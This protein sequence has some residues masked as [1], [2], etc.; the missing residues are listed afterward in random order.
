MLEISPIPPLRL[1]NRPNS[2]R[3]VKLSPTERSI[4]CCSSSNLW[5]DS[6]SLSEFPFARYD[7]R[8]LGGDERRA[9]SPDVGGIVTNKMVSVFGGA[10]EGDSRGSVEAE[11]RDWIG[12]GSDKLGGNYHPTLGTQQA[13]VLAVDDYSMHVGNH[14][15]RLRGRAAAGGASRGWCAARG[16]DCAPRAALFRRRAGERWLDQC[17]PC[18]GR[19]LWSTRILPCSC[20]GDSPRRPAKAVSV[21]GRRSGNFTTPRASEPI[22]LIWLALNGAD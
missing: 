18:L 12:S 5:Y 6:S 3:Q 2:N 13:D 9:M 7:W 19:V 21:F 1:P 10:R 11:E 14:A 4:L 16:A 22:R 8:S 15:G 20:A 17:R